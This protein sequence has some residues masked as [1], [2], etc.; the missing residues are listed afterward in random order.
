MN[1][2]DRRCA[3]FQHAERGDA[4][5][6]ARQRGQ[7]RQAMNVSSKIALRAQ[8]QGSGNRQQRGHQQHDESLPAHVELFVAC[9]EAVRR[10]RRIDRMITPAIATMSGA[11]AIL[12]AF[13]CE[14]KRLIS[15]S[16]PRWVSRNSLRTRVLSAVNRFNSA[17]CSGESMMEL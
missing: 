3:A 15:T 10:R 6:F 14:P 5:Q 9:T 13:S 7:E 12:I 17:S 8:V 16:R 11:M 4:V 1:R 2:Y